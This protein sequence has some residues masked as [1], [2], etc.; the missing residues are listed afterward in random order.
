MI[1]VLSVPVLNRPDLLD[2]M[3]AT[4]DVPVGR[5]YV[6]D[7]GDVVEDAKAP[8]DEIRIVRPGFNLGVARSWNLA[9]EANIE[10]PWWCLVNNDIEFGAGD[11]ARLAE[12]MEQPGPRVGCL[13]EFGA[14]GVNA[15]AMDRVGWFD[16]NYQP[17]YAEDCDWRWRAKLT[18]V[19]VTRLPSSTVHVDGGSLVWRSEAR[20]AQGNARTY[21]RN[22]EYH[23]RKWGGDPWQERFT[24]PF[25]DGSDP[26]LWDPPTVEALRAGRW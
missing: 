12:F 18:G 15:E 20:Y 1:P 13:L 24:T 7:N 17:I 25:D 5:L 2:R 21:P 6:I 26:T 3:L 9:I 8:A 22:V 19:E 16:E 23:R 10:A 11:L 14:F 4:V